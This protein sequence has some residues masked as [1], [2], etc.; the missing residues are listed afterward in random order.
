MFTSCH[1]L[2]VYTTHLDTECQTTHT[3][4]TFW[5]FC[6]TPPLSRPVSRVSLS[7]RYMSSSLPRNVSNECSFLDSLTV[8]N[9][10]LRWERPLCS[11]LRVCLCGGEFEE[12][13]EDGVRWCLWRF[14]LLGMCSHFARRKAVSIRIII[15]G[16]AD[17]N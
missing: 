16:R 2:S 14:K 15:L 7:F 11:S 17:L 10:C 13:E 8:C 4:L 3:L 1:A 6:F 9:A 12:L 5:K